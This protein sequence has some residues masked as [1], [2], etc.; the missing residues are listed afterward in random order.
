MLLLHL[1]SELFGIILLFHVSCV[2]HLS[3]P[4]T[5]CYNKERV[6]SFVVE[7]GAKLN[8]MKMSIPTT[9]CY[10]KERVGSFVVEMGAK[11]NSMKMSFLFVNKTII[12]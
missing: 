10:N 6:G 1:S 11:L 2:H 7:I 8:S 3:I 9:G 4:T 5:G 12:I